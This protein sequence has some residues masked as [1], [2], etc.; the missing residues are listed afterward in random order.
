MKRSRDD[1]STDSSKSDSKATLSSSS[2]NAATNSE[3]AT[4]NSSSSLTTETFQQKIARIESP[5]CIYY[6][7]SNDPNLPPSPKYAM[8]GT[9][10]FFM[11]NNMDIQ[12]RGHINHIEDRLN[13]ADGYFKPPYN[14]NDAYHLFSQ[15]F[16]MLS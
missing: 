13:A 7:R 8:A 10:I 16:S 11:A 1:C 3:N 15:F 14:G 4:S 2:E 12:I 5:M 9:I 6:P